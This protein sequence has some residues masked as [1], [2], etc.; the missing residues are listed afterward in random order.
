MLHAN[1]LRFPFQCSERL[2][3]EPPTIQHVSRQNICKAMYYNAYKLL[4]IIWTCRLTPIKRYRLFAAI[5]EGISR[6]AVI[7]KSQAASFIPY[8]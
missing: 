6:V 5:C 2:Y 8:T 3:E 7:K 1:A 4:R